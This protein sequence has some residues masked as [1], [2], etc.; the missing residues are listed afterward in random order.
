MDFSNCLIMLKSDLGISHNARDDYLTSVLEACLKE[1]ASRGVSL[2]IDG[3]VEDEML[4]SDYAAWRYRNRD[5]PI[6]LAQNL[7]IRINNKKAKGRCKL[8]E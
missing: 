7:Q 3:S 5:K 2:D 1:L 8:N 6:S 4:L